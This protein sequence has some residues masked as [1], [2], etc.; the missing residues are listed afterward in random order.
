MLATLADGVAEATP[1]YWWVVGFGGQIV[2]ASRFW[3]QWI[4]SERA[5]RSVV[6]ISFWWLSIFGGVLSLA[7]AIYRLDPVFIVGQATGSLIYVRNLALI[8]QARAGGV[9]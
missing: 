3:V 4:A 5:R 7:Y 1:W 8:N 9:G 6:P 2:F